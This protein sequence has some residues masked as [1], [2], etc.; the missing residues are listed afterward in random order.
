MKAVK[1]HIDNTQFFN[2]IILWL[3]ERE[4][5]K[6]V[7]PDFPINEKLG[8]TIKLLVD[9][10][11]HKPCF[12]NYTFKD[13]MASEAIYLCVKYAKNFNPEI[14]K[15][16]FAFFT[17]IAWSGFIK[18]IQQEKK[19]SVLKKELY[20]RAFF[21]MAN[22]EEFL[23]NMER[24]NI[25]VRFESDN[26]EIPFAPATVMYKGEKIVCE[27]EKDYLEYSEKIKKEYEKEKE[28]TKK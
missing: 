19:I 6:E 23:L 11:L 7:D 21:D 22:N 2:D 20:D 8:Y 12:S 9:H 5:N 24:N 25:E 15:N 3:R 17:Q 26:K 1:K 13:K 16:P 18:V 14:S 28:K 10:Y 27:T 4:M